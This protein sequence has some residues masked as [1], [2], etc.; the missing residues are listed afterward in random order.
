MDGNRTLTNDDC[1]GRIADIPSS[2]NSFVEHRVVLYKCSVYLVGLQ[3]DMRNKLKAS[4]SRFAHRG[5]V[6][7]RRIDGLVSIGHSM[8]VLVC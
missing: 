7:N 3:R 1:P 8:R 4:M 2:I 5:V 6:A